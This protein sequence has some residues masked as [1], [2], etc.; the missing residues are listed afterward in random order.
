M[1]INQ[2]VDRSYLIN[3]DARVDRL[4]CSS[5][6]LEENGISFQRFPAVNGFDIEN[7]TTMTDG[8]YGNYIS[9]LRVLEECVKDDIGTVAIFE[10]DV[11]FCD[12]FE[13]KFSELY[14]QVPSDWDMIYLGH[15]RPASTNVPTESPNVLKIFGAFA[16]HA[17]ILNRRAIEMACNDL[18]NTTQ[19][20]DVYYANAQST[21]NTYGFANQLCSQAPGWSDI[22]QGD[23]NYR[24]IFGWEG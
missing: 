9:H 5:K 4:E 17:F 24:W 15:N 6:Q 18:S 22:E 11:E 14:Y 3:L 23:R 10:D 8:Q 7:N 12:G 21:L 13:D 2:L 16:I 1:K 20:A 19:Q